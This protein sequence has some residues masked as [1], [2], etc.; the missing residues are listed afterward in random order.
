[1]F[2]LSHNICL[3][4]LKK[5]TKMAPIRLVIFTLLLIKLQ[6]SRATL[7][8]KMNIQTTSLS[9]HASHATTVSSKLQCASLCQSHGVNCQ[10]YLYNKMAGS[11]KLVNTNEQPQTTE[12]ISKDE[13]GYFNIGRLHT[14]AQPLKRLI[15]AH[16]K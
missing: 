13:M 5:V 15:T 16:S 12:I 7:F 2:N 11:C 3:S 9:V 6:P 10:V 4:N 1:M 14:L 8:K